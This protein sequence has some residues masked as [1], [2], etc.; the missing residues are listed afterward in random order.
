MKTFKSQKNAGRSLG[1]G[2][3]LLFVSMNLFLQ[4]GSISKY[5]GHLRR[6]SIFCLG[7]AARSQCYIEASPDLELRKRLL[8][9][10][11]NTSFRE[12]NHRQ[13]AIASGQ[14]MVFGTVYSA[15]CS[16]YNDGV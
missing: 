9:K 4:E 13:K 14:S 1:T 12:D 3:G 7:V 15:A 2:G 8:D 5:N 6:L 16:S 11:E 10:I